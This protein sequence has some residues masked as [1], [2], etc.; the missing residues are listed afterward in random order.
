MLVFQY[1]EEVLFVY[2]LLRRQMLYPAELR[3]HNLYN[4]LLYCITEFI[5]MFV[6]NKI[7][8]KNY[9]ETTKLYYH[10][11]ILVLNIKV[12]QLKLLP[13]QQIISPS[14]LEL[15][16]DN[17][18]SK[19]TN[20]NKIF[21]ISLHILKRLVFQAFKLSFISGEMGQYDDR[22]TLGQTNIPIALY[23]IPR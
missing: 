18:I 17:P 11:L 2:P 4:P 14:S 20:R 23:Y 21:Y 9:Q 15:N 13:Y 3:G 12:L 7:I 5:K 16:P 22:H 8:L 19:L 6:A 10:L 1:L